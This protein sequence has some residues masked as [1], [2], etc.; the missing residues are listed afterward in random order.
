ME[1]LTWIV[2]YRKNVALLFFAHFVDIVKRFRKSIWLLISVSI[3]AS[4][5]PQTFEADISLRSHLQS[6]VGPLVDCS[7][8]FQRC[9]H[10]RTGRDD[11]VETGSVAAC[12]CGECF[13]LSKL[14]HVEL[15]VAE[16][17]LKYSS[18][19]HVFSESGFSSFVHFS[20]SFR[21]LLF[22]FFSSLRFLRS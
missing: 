6:H 14:H 20:A 2:F 4:T 7:T 17:V 18:T 9:S 16:G 15:V 19:L 13:R 12:F 11:L 8:F 22:S 10:D 21:F 1:T 3:L 5:G